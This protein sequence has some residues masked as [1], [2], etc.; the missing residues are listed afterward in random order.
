MS[1]NVNS[2]QDNAKSTVALS[3]SLE[4]TRA[5]LQGLLRGKE[6]ENN[7]LT[8]QIKVLCPCNI[9]L[10]LLKDVD[11]FFFNHKSRRCPYFLTAVMFAFTLPT[12]P[13]PGA[14]Y[15]PAE[16]RD[17]ASARAAGETE[18]AGQR[19]QGVSERSD[20]SPQTAS[21][22]QRG[23]CGPAER[24]AAGHGRAVTRS[25]AGCRSIWAE[26]HTGG[27]REWSV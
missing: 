7:R 2:T 17:G 23:C 6:A 8:V 22:A 1:P 19:G 15:Q 25:G 13:E 21:C 27:R 24:A 9:L 3:K 4:S 10:L 20:A 12:G 18:A 14:G 16:G 5:H 11:H 26:R